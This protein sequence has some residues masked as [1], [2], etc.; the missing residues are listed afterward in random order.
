[1]TTS[2]SGNAVEGAS[3]GVNER[4][5]P[6][7][8]EIYLELARTLAHRSTCHR[9]SV[10][11]VITSTDYR[12][13]LAVGYNG[14]ATGLPNRCDREEPGNCGCL[15]SEE[16][17]VINCDSPRSVEKIAFVT[18]LPCMACAKRLINLGN[19]RKV[20]YGED[21]RLR[22]S[23]AV[24]ESV[25]IEVAQIELGDAWLPRPGS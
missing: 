19:V 18:H 11:T 15:H 14:N 6:S 25:G 3:V 1:M 21:Y 20:F 24:L 5:R 7:F 12:K 2:K 16:N 22:D 8:E 10:G 23:I 4:P 17:A 9:L 13:V